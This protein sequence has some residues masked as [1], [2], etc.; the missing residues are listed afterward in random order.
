M[1]RKNLVLLV[2]II[3]AVITLTVM[4]D[5][6]KEIANESKAQ[7][8]YWFIPDG[9]RAE[10]DLFN[11][12][13]WAQEGKL[14]NI[15]KMIDNGTFGYSVPTFPTH[16]PTN[17]AT[18]LTGAYPKTH[19]VADGP[20]H[21]EGKPLNKPS[22]GG[23]SSGSKK[24]APAWKIF[25][26][27]NKKVVILST[28]GSTPPELEDGIT[29]RGRWGGWGAD[30]HALIYEPEETLGLRKES[31]RG[32]R[33]FFL[34]PEL[35]QNVKM[36]IAS[37]WENTPESFSNPKQSKL[38][39]YGAEFF[40]YIF[41]STDDG[42]VNYDKVLFS[43]DKKNH[44]ETISKGQWSDWQ[45]VELT[46]NENKFDSHVKFEIIRLEDDGVYRIRLFFN[47]VNRYVT[48]PPEIAQELINGIGPMADFVD[49][50]PPQLIHYPEDKQA[51][52]DEAN[53]T[54]AWHQKAA[55]FILEKYQPDVFIHDIYTPNQMLTSKWW[56]GYVDPNS[57]RYNDVTDEEREILW[58]EVKDMYVNLDKIIGEAMKEADENSLIVLSSDHGAIPANKNFN[59]NN[60]LAKNGWLKFK[61]NEET[62]EPVIDYANS[63]ALY[64]KM[65]NIYIDPNGLEGDW[66]RAS[67]AEYEKLRQEITDALLQVQDE[68]GSKPV[69][70][71]INWENAEYLELPTD[72]VGD[73]IITN[74]AGYAWQEEMSADHE[75]FSTP[76]VTGYKQAIDSPQDNKGI[77]A[78][79]IVMGPGAKKGYVLESPISM[80]DQLPTILKLMDV[81]I[82]EYVEGRV[83]EEMLEK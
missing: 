33:L 14:P 26:E 53:M 81:V 21:V 17:F 27:A 80:V 13:K 37:D 76:I 32:V 12:Y 74:K 4:K 6:N 65:Y 39:A 56:M 77:W 2:V 41:D 67:G 46:W 48:D 7:K 28:P 52:I 51:F 64:L 31:G 42:K 35:T 82:P 22:M 83:L 1:K 30:I 73:L 71:V 78:P 54:F 59:V 34:G 79:F 20:M 23:F 45:N 15:K 36:D 63:K 19:G 11:V 50:F 9:M 10:P 25:E 40:I 38:T 70:E 44:Y 5:K 55:P 58:E 72:R 49:N 3:L 8:L 18:I 29:I 57:T 62:G 60:F 16:T 69:T 61:I 43:K 68:D 24:V 66:N 75:L 47:N